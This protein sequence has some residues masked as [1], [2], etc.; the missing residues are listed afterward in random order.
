M[1]LQKA[2]IYNQLIVTPV[3]TGVQMFC[4]YLRR[5][6]SLMIHYVSGLRQNDRKRFKIKV[7][8]CLCD[9]VAEWLHFLFPE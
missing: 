1:N 7:L 5:L 3:K 2:Y 8:L 4:N 9:L 6:D